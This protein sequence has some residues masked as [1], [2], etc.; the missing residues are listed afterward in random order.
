MNKK[1]GILFRHDENWI[2]GTYYILNLIHAIALLPSNDLPQLTIICEKD[3]DFDIIQSETNYPKLIKLVYKVGDVQQMG[4][5]KKRK[6]SNKFKELDLVF[7]F[8]FKSDSCFNLV[9]RKLYWIGDFQ[10]KY[11]PEFFSEKALQ[12]RESI[13]KRIA[14]S[15][16]EVVFSSFS[17][18]KDFTKFYGENNCKKYLLQFAVNHPAIDNNSTDKLFEKYKITGPYFISPNQFWAHKNHEL[19]INAVKVLVDEGNDVKLFFTGKEYDYRY[20][21]YT[22]NLKNKVKEFN[23]ENNIFFLGFIDRVEQ[24][25]L[26]KNAYA[27]IQ[28]SLFEGWSTVVEDTKALN[29]YIILSDLE[30]HR[31]QNP[32]AVSWFNPSKVNE[33]VLAMKK[34]KPNFTPIDYN[35]NKRIY[36]DQFV[37]IINE[38][39]K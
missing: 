15:N 5:F 2:G 1:I 13:N 19:I 30:V 27:V 33:L 18:L 34:E 24:L 10:E 36:V 14:S 22:I 12:N 38:V 39:S 21:D 26:M 9:K 32:V 31:E 23:L 4:W 35:I 11:L 20:P 25:L 28:A 8:P 16:S 7:P 17:A 29:N 6:Y 3:G 37:E